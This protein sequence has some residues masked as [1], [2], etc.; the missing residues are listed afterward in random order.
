M[1][2]FVNQSAICVHLKIEMT[3]RSPLR[4]LIN[5]IGF[6]ILQK[7]MKNLGLIFDQNTT[8]KANKHRQWMFSFKKEG[9]LSWKPV[10]IFLPARVKWRENRTSTL[11]SIICIT[12]GPHFVLIFVLSTAHCVT[13]IMCAAENSEMVI[14]WIQSNA[15]SWNGS[16]FNFLHSMNIIYF[17][18]CKWGFIHYKKLSAWIWGCSAAATVI[19]LK[20][21]LKRKKN[22]KKPGRAQLCLVKGGFFFSVWLLHLEKGNLS[23]LDQ[24]RFL[25]IIF[26]SNMFDLIEVQRHL[27]AFPPFILK[28]IIRPID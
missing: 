8:Q 6:N 11:A 1:L 27:R 24:I 20:F 28:Q 26:S 14:P 15:D 3:A 9:I 7:L 21:T 2:L 18:M 12:M 23:G 16:Y 17:D 22:L 10:W 19:P 5:L 25:W 4:F 13:I